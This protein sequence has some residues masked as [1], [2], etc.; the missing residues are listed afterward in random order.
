MEKYY[1][2]TTSE[3]LL[4]LNSSRA[5]LSESEVSQRLNRGQENDL[6]QEKHTSI[7]LK[8]IEQF[9]DLM[10][11]IL[12]SAS[13]VSIVIGAVQGS[14]GEIFDGAIILAIVIMN[15][16]FGVVQEYKAEKSLDALKKM[17]EPEA[18]V[19]RG[20]EQVKI[21]VRNI[22]VGDIV[23]LESGSI[24]P[25][26]VRILESASM[27]VDESSLTGESFAVK[28][29]ADECYPVNTPLAD[30]HNMAYKGCTVTA[31][32][33]SGV[34]V[35]IGKETEIGKIAQA[36]KNVEKEMTPLQKGI[37]DVGKVLTYL[38]LAMAAVTFFLEVVARPGNILEAFLTAVAISVAAIPESM[39]AVIT[40][41]MSMGVARLAKQKAIVKRMHSVETLGC[42]EVICSDKTGT[43]TQ[44]KMTIVSSFVDG[45]IIKGKIEKTKCEI[46][47]NAMLL[48][49]DTKKSK[50]RYV[51]DPTEV[52]L[53]EFGEKC[54]IDKVKLENL[55]QRV[56][57]I[58]F[59][60]KRKLMSTV[61]M[62]DGQKVIFTKGATDFLLKKCNKILINGQVCTINNQHKKEIMHA[63]SVMAED[64]LRV[65]A[66]AYKP[67]GNSEKKEEENLIFIGLVGMIDPPRKGVDKAVEKCKKAGMR[68]IMITGDH[69]DTAFAIAR[70]IGIV[71]KKSQVLTGSELDELSD[72]ELLKKIKDINVFARVSPDNKVRIVEILKKQGRVVAMTGDGVNDAPSLK[73][74]SIGIGMGIQGTDVTKEVADIIVTDD[75]F[76][77]IIVAVEEGRKIYQNIQKTVKFL[78]SANMGE[79]LSL[80]LATVFFP[81]YVFLFPVQ[82]LF[83]NLITDSLPAI[84]LGVE[85]PER[86]LMEARPRDSKK[87]LFSDGTGGAIVV[88]GL[89]QTLLVVGA[90]AFGLKLYNQYVASTMAF[91][92]LNIVQMFYLASMRTNGNMF[93]SNPFKN[94]FFTISILFC[95]GLLA[96]LALTPLNSMLKL[97]HLNWVQ[98]SII[99]GFSI[100]MMLASELYKWVYKLISKKKTT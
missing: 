43:I 17:T 35:A 73:K 82:I 94:K 29:I 87:S 26:D 40:I 61:N 55:Y 91:Y 66:I 68:P 56:D 15:A 5:G 96:I 90:Y 64:A 72:E 53:S 51:G 30:R 39:P 98:W 4:K 58:P 65:L 10:I 8:F 83:V 70:E 85:K 79:M 80:F 22:V 84:A 89:I 23:I 2:L 93:K 14:F 24:V 63:N 71:S 59:D 92:T 77:T 75:N 81:H 3:T 50:G 57:E 49:N 97:V 47:L 32:R 62:V 76:S 33:G 12:L 20:G 28:K 13:A 48:C 16:V 41:I 45:Q 6:G 78:F 38:V 25:A 1:N 36:I 46:F 42:C 74:A 95:F 27:Q 9:K 19:L 60:S 86:D 88:L 54:G 100:I 21:N 34:V 44:N 99:I 37:K 67:M 69:K 52:A 31:G 11:L 7:F 18:V